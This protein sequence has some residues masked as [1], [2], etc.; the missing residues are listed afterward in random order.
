MEYPL[1]P[2]T[3][4]WASFVPQKHSV[5]AGPCSPADAVTW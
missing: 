2:R 3:D 1:E 5:E 4:A